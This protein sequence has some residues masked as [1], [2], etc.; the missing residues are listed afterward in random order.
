MTLDVI[1]TI[2][3]PIMLIRL[4][5][6]R[7]QYRRHSFRRRLVRIPTN[8]LKMIPLESDLPLEIHLLRKLSEDK[9]YRKH[10]P[11]RLRASFLLSTFLLKIFL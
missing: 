7:L 1:N 3:Y 11:Q 9:F 2:L 4:V 5:Y 10:H 8:H 6:H